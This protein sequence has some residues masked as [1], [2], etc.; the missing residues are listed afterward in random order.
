ML[1][2]HSD[3][4]GWTVSHIDS[5]GFLRVVR[6]G[7]S[8]HQVAPGTSVQILGEEA[9]G[10]VGAS[11]ADAAVLRAAQADGAGA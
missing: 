4:I 8:D 2:A 6:N 11:N 1:E 3:E 9:V 10:V 7:G 5:K